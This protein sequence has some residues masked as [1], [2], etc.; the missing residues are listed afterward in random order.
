MET[1]ILGGYQT[2]DIKVEPIPNLTKIPIVVI[3]GPVTKSAGSM[4]AIAFKG[5]PN[6]FVIGEPTADGYTTSNGYFQFA[7]N[8]TL[9]FATNYVADRK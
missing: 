8:L 2:T 5:R 3:I 7:P 4:L 1:F 9:N 6:T